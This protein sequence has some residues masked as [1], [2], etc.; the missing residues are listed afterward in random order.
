MIL[1]KY[2][3]LTNKLTV[4]EEPFQMENDV[5]VVRLDWTGT[6]YEDWIKHVS[7]QMSSDGTGVI[8]GPLGTSP[9]IDYPLL[10]ELLVDG[11]IRIQGTA[12][13]GSQVKKFKVQSVRVRPSLQIEAYTPSMTDD[14][15]IILQGKVFTLENEMS[16]AQSDV[17]GLESGKAPLVHSHDDLYFT[18]AEV[19]ALLSG[20]ASTSHTHDDR[21]YTETEVGILLA[22]KMNVDGLNSSI[23][24]LTFDTTPAS[25]APL[26]EGQQRWDGDHRTL[27]VGLGGGVVGQAFEESFYP[28]TKNIDDVTI[29][30]GQLVMYA[31]TNGATGIL[32]V[33]RANTPLVTLPGMFMGIATEN[34]AK[35]AI[36]K[37]TWFG[38]INGVPTNGALY[39]ESWADS[40]ILYNHPTIPGGLS[41]TKPTAP[42]AATMVGIVVRAHATN[43]ILF[44]RP[45]FFPY[46]WMLSDVTITNP[47]T[48]DVLVRDA[49][50]FWKN[51]NS[52]SIPRWD[53]L[54]F[55]LTQTRQGSNLKPDFDYTNI[56]LL[57]PQNDQT[58]IVYITVQ[59][60]HR[61]VEGSD[62]HPHVHVV[63]AENQQATF[64]MQYKWY[65][66]GDAIPGSWTDFNMNQYSSTY[67]SGSMANIVGSAA[68]ISGTGKKISSILKIKLF[69]VDNV[70]VGDILADHFDI[71]IQIDGFGSSTEFVK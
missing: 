62:I 55:P 29:E 60:P 46:L 68:A 11:Y 63:Q 23:D 28:K 67:V 26:A 8:S 21:Y 7:I 12:V 36:G 10:D 24:V 58:E 52:L 54:Q 49:G 43:G 70:Y 71:H 17:A 35:N 41:K 30:D 27:D 57:F 42:A 34:I 56:G 51:S 18:E 5:T 37:V 20:K 39:G 22:N 4:E 3:V 50:G 2:T 16:Q 13:S 33:K 66:Q 47:V 31:G 25:S 15:F 6:I 44:V 64:R 65:N 38:L 32:N 9:I 1:I 53:D 45:Q 61:W 14:A 48:G 19:V 59:L 69:R 40:T